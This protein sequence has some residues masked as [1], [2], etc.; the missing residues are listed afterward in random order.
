MDSTLLPPPPPNLGPVSPRTSAP[1]RSSGG[2]LRQ[3]VLGIVGCLV[4]LSFFGSAI[5]LYRITDVN[6]SL[7]SINRVS[8]PLGRLF[9]QMQSDADVLKRELDRRLGNSHWSDPHWK[10]RPIP[11]WIEDVITS[12]VLRAQVLISKDLPWATPEARIKWRQWAEGLAQGFDGLKAE[13][14]RI[15]VALD[16]KDLETAAQLY[17]HWTASLDSWNRQLQWGVE[18]YERSLRQTFTQ[19]EDRVAE[20]R[21]GLEITVVVVVCLSLLLLWLGERALRPLSEL[22]RLA[23]EITRRGPRR[24]DKT[25]LPEIALSRNDEV[26]QL[27]REF[28]RMATALLERE[29]IVDSQKSRLTDQNRQLREIGEMNRNILNSIESVLIVTDLQGR[30]TQCNPVA[31]RWL[32]RTPEELV[33]TWLTAW[34]EFRSFGIQDGWTSRVRESTGVW[35]IEPARVGERVY[36]GQ[37]MPLWQAGE[38]DVIGNAAHPA[39]GAI[40]VLEDLTEDLSLQE[41]LR[42]A[43]KLAAVGRMSAQVAH[44]VRNPLHSIGLEA[45]LAAEAAAKLGNLPLKQSLQ[46]I[47]VAVDRLEKITENYLKLSRLSAGENTQLDLGQTLETVLAA[48]APAFEAQ[49]VRVDWQR[50]TN[51][52]FAVWGDGDL[53][54][55]ALG[56]LLRNSLQALE[57]LP[58]GQGTIDVRLG[59]TESNRIWLQI[60]DNGPGIEP[61]VRERL[62]SPFVTTRA[63]GTGLGLSFVKKVLEDHSGSVSSLDLGAGQGACFELLIPLAGARVQAMSA[64]QL[65]L[66]PP[67]STPPAFS[68]HE[69]Y[70]T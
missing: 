60:R 14:A 5:S 41:R 43:E 62:F 12:E 54:E 57:T 30:I 4:M 24:E 59:N 53:L 66:P 48:Y 31:C 8:V 70:P 40:W 21:T 49:G 29:K 65:I 20:L 10:P 52:S 11:H 42:D 64:P 68:P 56:N 69:V 37:V 1:T 39:S 51:A 23:R 38:G 19:A 25:A 61:S 9:T 16:Q 15:Y 6:R 45:E 26:S 28:H 67:F 3:R 47:L 44:E 2:T 34:P 18:E 55:N 13:A 63:Q 58:R 22:T 50:E 32:A 33:G 7:D 36:G 17:P 46:S 35:R 27:A